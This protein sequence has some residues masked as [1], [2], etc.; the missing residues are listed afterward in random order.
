MHLGCLKYYNDIVKIYE[1]HIKCCGVQE[2]KTNLESE[3]VED[4][5]SSTK[6]VIDANVLNESSESMMSKMTSEN[7]RLSSETETYL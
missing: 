6:T 7:E 5:N 3:T 2:H 4:L 1:T